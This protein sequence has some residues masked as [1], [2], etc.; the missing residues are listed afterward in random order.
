MLYKLLSFF[1]LSYV[2]RDHGS[3]QLNNYAQLIIDVTDVNDN[4]PNILITEINGTNHHN[5]P[6]IL[7]ECTPK[8]NSSNER[9]LTQKN[10]PF[11]DT[12]L[13]YIYITDEDSGE[14][15]RVSCV[16]NDTRLNLKYLTLNAYSL[17]IS[18][19]P[20]FDYELE[21]TIDIELKCTD[22]GLPSL[23]KTVLFQIQL[24]DCNDNPPDI[25]SPLPFNQTLFIPF[26]TTE[27]PFIIT[28]FIVHDRDRF[29]SNIFSY[30]FTV[31]PSMDLSLTNNGTL[32]LRSMPLMMGFYTIN[33][34]VY[35][36]GNLTNSISIPID[37]HSINETMLIKKFNMD[38]TGL[39]LI[40]SFFVIIFIASIFIG[41][42]FLIAFLFRRKNPPNKC[43]C[44][45]SCFNITTKSARNSSCE[46]M[47]SSNERADSSQKTTI[48]VLDDGRVSRD[49]FISFCFNVSS[50]LSIDTYRRFSIVLI[51]RM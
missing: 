47:N 10:I 30:S 13:Y 24:E 8:G 11:S 23:S 6:I 33:V 15:G 34:T 32:I 38:N 17:Q 36:L 49:R 27:T 3:P 50:I 45:Y 40:L 51:I 48:E 25:I 39:I 14:N 35:D 28:Q 21:Q 7:P 43:L 16:L 41:L 42:C 19:S 5:Q 20:V 29:Q 9:I 1:S 46:S 26:E 44:C 31:T 22:Y 12:S 4:I 18:G 37:I 2:A